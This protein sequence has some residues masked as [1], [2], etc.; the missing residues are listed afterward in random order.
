MILIAGGTGFIGRT[1]CHFLL[2]KGKKVGVLSRNTNQPKPIPCVEYY[3][4]HPADKQIDAS[5]PSQFEAIIN[6]CGANVAEGRWT[7]NRKQELLLSRTQSTQFLC[8]LIEEEKVKTACFIQM[9]AIG[10]Y[11]E[12]HSKDAFNEDAPH[13]ENF[14]GLTCK[15]WEESLS[16]DSQKVRSVVLRLGLVAAEQGGFLAKLKPLLSLQIKPIF[17]SGSQYWSWIHIDDLCRLIAFAIAS[18]Q[19][20]G[21]FNAV[22]SFTT[23]RHIVDAYFT[24][25]KQWAVPLYI[26]AFIL[27]IILGE[28]SIELLKSCQVANRK[29]HTHHF[30]FTYPTV[31]HLFKAAQ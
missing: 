24:E 12:S 21:V 27:K 11:G 13:A 15:A 2:T 26:P 7:K 3:T 20:S 17:G 4:W 25:R 22:A 6:V 31:E 23:Q 1:L 5:L 19:M 18:K 10:F 28:M 30:Q 9:S 16:I 8:A 29:I 14:L